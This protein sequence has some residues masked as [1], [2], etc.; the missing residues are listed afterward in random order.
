MAANGRHR[1]YGDMKITKTIHDHGKRFANAF[2]TQPDTPP[3]GPPSIEEVAR[4]AY[5]RY[6]DQ[7]SQPGNDVRNWL[8]AESR[9]RADSRP[10]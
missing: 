10:G 3:S 5:F 1:P 9:L 6:V 8:E 2:R 4:S 7:G